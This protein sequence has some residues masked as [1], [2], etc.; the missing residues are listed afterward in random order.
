MH[1]AFDDE[2]FEPA[3][4]R[5]DTVLTLGPVMGIGLF[6]GLALLCGLSFGAGYVVGHRAP[7]P[8]AALNNVSGDKQT[9]P[10]ADAVKT[11]PAA[12]GQNNQAKAQSG[13]ANRQPAPAVP[14]D[15]FAETSRARDAATGPAFPNPAVRP[16]QP[17]A[18]SAGWMVQIAAVSHQEDAEVLEGAL[19]KRGYSVTLSRDTVD[20]LI[21]VRIGP[22][23]SHD[24]A[25]NWRQKLLSDG[26]NAMLQ[27]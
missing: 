10:T 8:V 12:V 18:A 26:Y 17:A 19:R 7:Q 3:E 22:F 1:G 23:T 25:A 27:P 9:Q 21:H 11:K 15:E 16:T 2:E 20:G 6:L 5:S 14:L 4:Q 13:S 24:E